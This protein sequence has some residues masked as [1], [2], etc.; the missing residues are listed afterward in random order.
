MILQSA[1]PTVFDVCDTNVTLRV[2][3]TT[4]NRTG[5][6]GN[7]FMATRIWEAYDSCLNTSKCSQVVTVV[8]T[9]PPNLTCGSNQRSEER[10]S[11]KLGTLSAT[12]LS[13]RSNGRNRGVSTTT[14]RRCAHPHTRTRR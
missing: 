10:R 7:T 13:Y 3:S 14:Y 12:A 9:T 1:S 11:W 5:F 4:T 6:C 8:D 2:V